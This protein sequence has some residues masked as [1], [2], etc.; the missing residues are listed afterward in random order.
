MQIALWRNIEYI[1][2]KFFFHIAIGPFAGFLFWMVGDSVAE[3]QLRLFAVFQFIFVAPGIIGTF[4][5]LF[6]SQIKSEYVA[7]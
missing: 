5:P 2:N 1:N 7:F 6:T 3:M 4:S